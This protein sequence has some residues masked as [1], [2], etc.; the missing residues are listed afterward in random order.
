ML[1][2][3]LSTHTE[4]LTMETPFGEGIIYLNPFRR[5]NGLKSLS[6]EG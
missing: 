4:R 5:C 2:S 6:E 1:Y 3:D